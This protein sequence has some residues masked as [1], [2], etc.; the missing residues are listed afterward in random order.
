MSAAQDIEDTIQELL[1]RGDARKGAE[2]AMVAFGPEIRRF[3]LALA[4]DEE[5]ASEVFAQFGEDLWRGIGGFQGRSSFRT[6]AYTIAR[7]AHSRYVRDPYRRRGTHLDESHMNRVQ[8]QKRTETR[9]YMK[10]SAR[11]MLHGFRQELQE[12]DQELLFLRLEERMAW[13]DIALKLAGHE[14]EGKEV[15]ARAAALR[16]RFERIKKKLQKRVDEV[17]AAAS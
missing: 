13:R 2:V 17:R 10:T 1:A 12:Q 15:K 14:L 3:L 5:V 8:S 7:N 4:R 11:K 9:V 6:W 16:K